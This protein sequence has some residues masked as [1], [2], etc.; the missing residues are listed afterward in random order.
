M[1]LRKIKAK[2]STSFH[3]EKVYTFKMY[4]QILCKIIILERLKFKQTVFAIN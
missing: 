1:H 4:L 3:N 2:F